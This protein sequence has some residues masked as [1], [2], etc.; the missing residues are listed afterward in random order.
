ML[1]VGKKVKKNYNLMD[2]RVEKVKNKCCG[3]HSC[4]VKLLAA[5]N[6]VNDQV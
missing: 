6:L 4:G 5:V 2:R 1:A 3:G